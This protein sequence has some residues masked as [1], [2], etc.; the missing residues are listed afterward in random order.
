MGRL[1]N[2]GA[3]VR[4]DEG[5]VLKKIEEGKGVMCCSDIFLLL[6]GIVGS[7]DWETRRLPREQWKE[8]Q[9]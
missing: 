5:R 2:S 3:A 8:P 9:G 4:R 7:A 6:M 1:I